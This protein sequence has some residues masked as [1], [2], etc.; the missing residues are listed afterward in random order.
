MALQVY[1][2]LYPPVFFLLYFMPFPSLSFHSSR[3]LMNVMTKR[4]Y[5]TLLIPHISSEKACSIDWAGGIDVSSLCIQT[6]SN[7]QRHVITSF[8]EA[9]R[10]DHR[11]RGVRSLSSSLLFLSLKGCCNVTDRLIK[12]TVTRYLSVTFRWLDCDAVN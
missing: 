10:S 1:F 7:K 4:L 11:Q 3:C 6:F 9:L 5:R 8:K 2:Q 12:T